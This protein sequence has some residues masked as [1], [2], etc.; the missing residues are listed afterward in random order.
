MRT[1]LAVVVTALCLSILGLMTVQSPSAF[2][3]HRAQVCIQHHLS[4]DVGMRNFLGGGEIFLSP[5]ERS[6]KLA[7]IQNEGWSGCVAV[8]PRVT[9]V[10]FT[11][12][13]AFVGYSECRTDDKIF[14]FRLDGSA[15][16]IF[17]SSNLIF[18]PAGRTDWAWCP[19]AEC[20]ANYSSLFHVQP[21]D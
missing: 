11:G 18:L 6:E 14:V 16:A 21:G 3:T 17:R 10:E 4:C 2:A 1:L 7:E 15:L 5:L 19:I 9:E 8:K 20:P 12:G 13:A